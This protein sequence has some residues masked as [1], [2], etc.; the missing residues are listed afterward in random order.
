M[1]LPGKTAGQRLG[2]TDPGGPERH[3]DTEVIVSTTLPLVIGWRD[4]AAPLARPQMRRGPGLWRAADQLSG[5][6]SAQAHP[7]C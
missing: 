7:R 4:A 3:P 2:G 1:V 5:S 6:R